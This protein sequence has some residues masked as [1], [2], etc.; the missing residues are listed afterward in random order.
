MEIV[1]LSREVFHRTQTRPSHAPVVVAVWNGHSEP[2]R[3]GNTTFTGEALSL[4]MS[5]HA[6]THLDAPVRF[7][8]RPGALSMG[9]VPLERFCTS[10]IRPG[11][12]HVPLRR[13]ATVPEM[14]AALE[15]SGQEVRGGEAVLLHMAANEPPPGKPGCLHGFPG[16]APESVHWLADRGVGVFGVEAISPAP[17]GGPNFQ[18]HLACAGRGIT[19][20]GCLANLDRLAGR[21]RFRF[22]GFPLKV[23]GGTASPISA[24]AAFDGDAA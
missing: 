4:A 1:D 6:G 19:H 16:L 11:L 22:I 23:R 5:D 21:G 7:D 8:P 2:K 20:I 13:A 15:A 9:R 10:G 12:S 14:E 17:E 18:A 3:A 24:A